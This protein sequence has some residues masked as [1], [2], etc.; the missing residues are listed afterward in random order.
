MKKTKSRKSLAGYFKT[1]KILIVEDMQNMRRAI[2]NILTSM[3]IKHKQIIQANDGDIALKIL[4]NEGQN[5]IFVLLDWN[6]PRVPGI[7]VLME[8]KEDDHL[9]KIPVLI[10]T[11]ETNEEQ[12]VQ[13]VEYNV[14][15]YIIK[16]FIAQTLREKMLNIINPPEYL[17]L[18]EE[19]E[20]RI[21]QGRFDEALVILED[22]LKSKPDSAS[23][24]ILMGKAYE[25]IKENEKARQLYEEAIEKNPQYLRAHDVLSNFLLKTGKK[26]EALSS[27]EVAVKISPL[28]AN[29]QVLVGNLALETRGDM[30]RAQTAF[31]AAMKQT[32]QMAEEIAEIYLKNGFHKKAEEFFRTS[33]SKEKNAYIYNRLGIA[34]RKQKKWKKAI[35]EYKKA[36]SLEPDDD[37]IFYNMA[38]AYLEGD[39]IEG[40]KKKDAI[41]CLK[42]ASGINPNFMDAKKMLK[43]LQYAA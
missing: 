40:G 43:K 26:E 12:I 30:E 16:P 3:G 29:R 33:L 22:V 35:E 1:G 14:K 24:R 19:G 8:I 17:Q 6:M 36:L 2:K 37:A 28:N 23:I 27:L 4:R 15:N 7:E 18:I 39:K 34:L 13:A 31:R 42:K 25:E 21:K 11:A 20:K 5:I 9:R 10:V 41:R 38:M 32:P